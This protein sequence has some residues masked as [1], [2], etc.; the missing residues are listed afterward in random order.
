MVWPIIKNAGTQWL[1]PWYALA[2]NQKWG[3]N[4]N[5]F[6]QQVKSFKKPEWQWRMDNKPIVSNGALIKKTTTVPKPVKWAI[7]GA[8]AGNMWSTGI[9][10]P[11]VTPFRKGFN[12]WMNPPPKTVK[13]VVRDWKLTSPTKPIIANINLHK[14][15]PLQEYLWIWMAKR[16]ILA[17]QYWAKKIRQWA[18]YVSSKY[19][20]SNKF[21]KKVDT[22]INKKVAPIKEA[23]WKVAWTVKRKAK[24]WWSALN[25][26]INQ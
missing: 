26:P 12:E 7:G 8:K 14:T 15:S 19:S 16:G 11:T 25:A 23:V 3:S 21:A 1:P 6:L 2:K 4:Y 5:N 20:Q 24:K 10:T 22:G 9:K 18:N 17:W 13:P